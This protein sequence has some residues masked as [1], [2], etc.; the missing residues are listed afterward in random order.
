M[1]IYLLLRKGNL[2]LASYDN[3]SLGTREALKEETF[4]NYGFAAY[5]Y[6][7]LLE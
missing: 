2:W 4:L 3:C 5:L 1:E 7:F 6:L